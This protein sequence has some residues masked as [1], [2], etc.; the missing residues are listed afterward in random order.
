[1]IRQWEL[2]Y[3]AHTAAI[4][5]RMSAMRFGCA[6][7][8]DPAA[9][10][11]PFL[12]P[13]SPSL[14]SFLF[15]LLR[16]GAGAGAPGDVIQSITARSLELLFNKINGIHISAYLLGRKKALCRHPFCPRSIQGPLI[17]RPIELRVA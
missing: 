9:C 13:V 17:P 2:G 12:P 1:M 8:S 15:R 3:L 5:L 16:A 10:G 7:A 6:T 4:N 11:L 14:F